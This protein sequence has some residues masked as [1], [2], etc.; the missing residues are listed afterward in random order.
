MAEERKNDITTEVTATEEDVK[1]LKK[2]QFAANPSTHLPRP[3]QVA[4]VAPSLNADLVQMLKLGKKTA[5]FSG[6]E[7][8]INVV[9][10]N[11]PNAHHCMSMIVNNLSTNERMC[12]R[13]T[14]Q[15]N[16]GDPRPRIINSSM[17]RLTAKDLEECGLEKD[18]Y[19]DMQTGRAQIDKPAK[20]LAKTAEPKPR[21]PKVAV[22]NSVK[23][24]V[25]MEE[26][27]KDPDILKILL[28]KT[29][30]SIFELPVKNF[31]EAEEIRVVKERVEGFLNEKA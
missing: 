30:E 26:L 20:K 10:P 22:P 31:R 29:L 15:Q 4:E 17:I 27:K 12:T 8:C 7:R 9:D 23:I 1:D 2:A 16:A 18:P 25:T 24:E 28:N 21:R 5:M 6:I 3:S 11:T 19:A 13:C 14:R